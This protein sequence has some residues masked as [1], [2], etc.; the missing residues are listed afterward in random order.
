MRTWEKWTVASVLILLFRKRIEQSQRHIPL[1]LAALLALAPFIRMAV[2]M[3]YRAL[4]VEP[5]YLEWEILHNYIFTHYDGL[6]M[7]LIFASVL[8]FRDSVS[9]IRNTLKHWLWF[10]V[11]L[12]GVLTFFFRVVFIYSFATLIFG[13]AIWHCLNKPESSITR[14]LS[15]PGFQILSRLSY[16][17]YLWYRFPLWRIAQFAL[18][19]FP[20]AAPVFQYFLIFLVD[21]G[22]A[23]ILAS[24]TYVLI[25]RPFLELRS[26]LYRTRQA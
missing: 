9:W 23:V 11:L 26:K 14:F 7:G 20:Q 18:Q 12:T 24:I 25:E 19:H 5:F 10:L 16:G 3:H 6:A 15:W 21:F 13:T 1:F 22:I 4:Q 2:W 17:M 8:V